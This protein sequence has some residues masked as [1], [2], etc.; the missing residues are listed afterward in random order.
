MAFGVSFASIL[1]SLWLK[2]GSILTASH[3]LVSQSVGVILISAAI[4]CAIGV[5][6]ALLR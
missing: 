6:T 2:G 5:A 4:L 1:L 3:G